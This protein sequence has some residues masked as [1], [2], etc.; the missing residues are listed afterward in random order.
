[1][2]V[3]GKIPVTCYQAHAS[4]GLN[5]SLAYIIHHAGLVD[6]VRTIRQSQ[7]VPELATNA[8][9]V[10]AGDFV[11]IEDPYIAG[12]APNLP[13]W[14]I[15]DYRVNNIKPF[16][17]ARWSGMPNP[18][19]ARKRSDMES[20][21]SITGGGTP[22]Q[23]ILGDFQTGNVVVKVWDVWG[24]WIDG[25]DGNLYDVRGSYYSSGTAP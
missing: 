11:P 13:W 21:T 24:T 15:S 25:T 2:Q 12:T 4:D 6:T 8:A 14:A 16:V 7:L 9:N 17:L 20:I 19:L 5:A 23:P 3:V 18:V 10:I 22:M 1:M